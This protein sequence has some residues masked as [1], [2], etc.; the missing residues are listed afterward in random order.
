MNIIGLVNPASVLNDDLMA[1]IFSFVGGGRGKQRHRGNIAPTILHRSGEASIRLMDL[2]E[3]GRFQFSTVALVCKQWKRICQDNLSLVLGPLNGNFYT[4]QNKDRTVACIQWMM[5]Y[6]LRI[7]ALYFYHGQQCQD[8]ATITQL[9]QEC[10]TTDL[11]KLAINLDITDETP[12]L[13]RLVAQKCPNLRELFLSVDQT[14]LFQKDHPLF[15]A[16][17]PSL[18]WLHVNLTFQKGARASKALELPL[19]KMPNLKDLR[20]TGGTV[21]GCVAVHSE[22][23]Q[24]IDACDLVDGCFV[25]C[26]CPKLAKFSCSGKNGT[27]PAGNPLA[28]RRRTLAIETGSFAA[29]DVPFIGMVVP[30]SCVVSL[31]HYTTEHYFQ[32]H[33]HIRGIIMGTS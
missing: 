11:Q 1:H 13:H 33:A 15:L 26:E 7:G 2:Q 8:V 12:E 29:G 18:S 3:A 27:F 22:S 25:R 10:D 19:R 32:E 31:N 21:W 17:L 23:L 14:S 16:S 6:K 28:F 20:L 4:L 30:P 5:R 9:L 24:Q